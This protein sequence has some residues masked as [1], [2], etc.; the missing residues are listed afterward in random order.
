M[1]LPRKI[2]YCEMVHLRHLPA[3]REA[4]FVKICEQVI[5]HITLFM[6][7]DMQDKITDTC[8]A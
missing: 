7:Y 2:R 6:E 5:N 3:F 4:V 8:T 1:R